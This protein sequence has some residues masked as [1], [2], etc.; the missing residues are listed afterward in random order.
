MHKSD[1]QHNTHQIQNGKV[2]YKQ[3]LSYICNL[4]NYYC[5]TPVKIEQDVMK[6][7]V[8]ITPLKTIK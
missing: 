4:S 6:Q 8:I 7:P 5:T 2:Y 1:K 3:H